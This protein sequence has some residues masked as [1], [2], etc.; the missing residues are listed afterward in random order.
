MKKHS[1][2]FAFIILYF[3]AY[4][5]K[6]IIDADTGN[7]MDDLYAIAYLLG[8][9]KANV[10]ALS[11]AHFNNPDLLTEKEW[12][13]Y[14]TKNI[15]PLEISYNL[16]KKLLSYAN[17]EDILCLEGAKRMIGRAW[18]GNT[19]RFSAASKTI[20]D[21]AL[22]M[23]EGQKLVVFTLGPL[24]NV[25]SAIIEQP[26]IESK[27]VLYMM[28]ANYYPEKNVWDK[29]EFNIRNDLNAFDYLLNS[30]V[31]MH[32]M[33]ANASF[34]FQ[35]DKSKTLGKLNKK[36]KL[37]NLLASKWDAIKADK[38]WIMWDLALI[39][40]YFKPSLA[41][42]IPVNTPPENTQRKVFVYTNLKVQE[43]ENHF[44]KIYES[45]SYLSHH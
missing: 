17:R 16:N 27:I 1:L 10:I 5:Q 18:G 26:E 34:A 11:A 23:P 33:T 14:K 8:I 45:K 2:F 25:A 4:S 24:T 19:P 15:K 40:A 28:G 29:S 38:N 44:W 13:G 42:E 39:I 20:I 6:I 31:E 7:E 3:Q 36:N 12:N 9:K 41:T 21:E 37:D 22:K 32:I 30:T 43:M 35:F